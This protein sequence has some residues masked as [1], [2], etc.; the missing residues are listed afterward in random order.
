MKDI[1]K[2]LFVG[3]V[4]LF[5]GSSADAQP[6]RSSGIAITT[7]APTWIPTLRGTRIAWDKVSHELYYYDE[8]LQGWVKQTH[9]S[10]QEVSNVIGDSLANYTTVPEV[11]QM[12]SDSLANLSS[13]NIYTVNGN[14]NDDRTIVGSGTFSL[15]FLG[16]NGFDVV[17]TNRVRLTAQTEANIVAPNLVSM[18]SDNEV[19]IG[20]KDMAVVNG[21]NLVEITSQNHSHIQADTKITLTSSNIYLGTTANGGLAQYNSHSSADSDASLLSG[22]LYKLVDD[23]TVYQKP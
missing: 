11:G 13:G 17:S 15:G 10:I 12:I 7:S 20:S 18:T 21:G 3:I 5:V 16:V 22:S 9:L 1:L 4:L 14:L 2:Y 8:G 23:R 6:I 19:L